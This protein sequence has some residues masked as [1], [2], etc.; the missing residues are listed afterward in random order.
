MDM[1][2][3]L[4]NLVPQY[5]CDIKPYEPGKPIE[6]VERELGI[7][8]SLKM[9][10]NENPLGPSPKAISAIKKMA[11]K[12][13]Y[14]P[15]GGSPYLLASLAKK[16]SVEP[17]EI[18]FGNG[19]NEVI[20]LLMRCLLIKGDN[21]VVSKHA[22]VVYKLIAQ[23]V[24]AETLEAEPTKGLGHDLSAMAKL[25]NAKT[26]II[27]I[28]NPNN[29]TG[30]YVSGAELEKFMGSVPKIPVVVDEAYY[31]YAEAKDYPDTIRMRKKYPNIIS[32]RT[33]SKS[34]GLAGLRIGYG[35]ADSEL[36]GYLNRL[37]QPFNVNMLAQAGALAALGDKAYLKKS[38]KLNSVGKK[39]LYKEFEKA[40]IEYVPTEANFIL[41]N[42][43]NGR[44]VFQKLQMEGVIVRPMDVYGLPDYIRVT[45]GKKEQNVRFMKALKKVLGS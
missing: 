34:Y 25:V 6:E 14:Y 35:I 38:Q 10:S 43:G 17:G 27:F 13:H 42:V 15:E 19:S 31:D 5:I 1:K 39:Q 26:K 44:G 11:S 41:V 22:F 3:E 7:K 29:P 12:V 36:V 37:R 18:V 2:K 20:E 40:G 23:G 4:K 45:I 33:F 32:L 21:I 28:A 30:T 16:L 8:N 9:A 24:G